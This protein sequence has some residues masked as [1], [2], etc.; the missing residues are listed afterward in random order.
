MTSLQLT[1]LETK[2]LNTINKSGSSTQADFYYNH[3][4]DLAKRDYNKIIKSL[5]KKGLIIETKETFQNFKNGKFFKGSWS[6]IEVSENG[7]LAIQ[8]T[9]EAPAQDQ[10]EDQAELTIQEMQQA[11]KEALKGRPAFSLADC[12]DVDTLDA[13]NGF[14]DT[15]FNADQAIDYLMNFRTWQEILDDNDSLIDHDKLHRKLLA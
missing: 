7:I 13:L 5:L 6:F 3:F 11:R 14:Y 8:Q 4:Y 2:V 10:A 1:A 9:Q 15:N 12:V